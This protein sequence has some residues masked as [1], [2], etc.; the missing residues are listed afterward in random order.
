MKQIILFSLL[1][2]IINIFSQEQQEQYSKIK[3][4]LFEKDI[5]D[6]AKLGL[7]V[8]HGI[9]VKDRFLINDYSFS[10]MKLI[11]KAKFNYEVLIEDV[12]SWYQNQHRDCSVVKAA[13]APPPTDCF[14]S[15]TN[16][17][18]FNTPVNYTYGSMGGYLTYPELL[19]VLDSMFVKFPNL[20]T[21]KTPIGTLAD[22]TWMGNRIQC[23]KI[24]DNPNINEP[25]PE[26]LFTSLH[27][28]REPNSLAQNIFYMWYLLEN[29]STDAEIKYLVDNTEIYFIPCVNPDGYIMNA[30]NYP[31]GGGM[32]RKNG[33]DNDNNGIYNN[34][35][36]VDLNRNYGHQ[37]AYDN[38]GSSPNMNSQTYR[39]P[40]AFSEPE[41]R[42]VRDFCNDHEFQITMNYHTY[43][44]LLI[45]PWGYTDVATSEHETF[46]MLGLEMTQYN[47]Y[48]FG[49]GS[50]T[51]GYTV[52]GDSDDWMYGETVTKGKIYSMTP[53][54][55][56]TG[57]WPM[58]SE[59][60]DLNK[61]VMHQNLS[62]SRLVL[63]YVESIDLN[64]SPYIYSNSGNLD[65]QFVKKGL[66]IGDVTIDFQSLNPNLSFS[67]TPQI[68]SLLHLETQD[69]SPVYNISSAVNDEE[70]KFVVS[71]NN[72]L[73]TYF[74]TIIKIYKTSS[75]SV[76]FDDNTNDLSNWTNTGDWGLTS[77][78]YYTAPNSITD[79]PSSDYGQGINSNITLNSIDLTY[80]TSAFIS[81]WAKWNIEND[82]D[83]TEIQI[84]TDGG[85]NYIPLCGN[86]SNEGTSYQDLGMPLYDGIQDNWVNEIID[87][88]EYVG[89]VVQFRFTFNSDFGVEED[90]FYFDEFKVESVTIAHTH[91][92]VVTEHTCNEADT[93]TT[94]VTHPN[95][96]SLDSVYTV[97][98]VLADT[99]SNT[100]NYYTLDISQV[101][102]VSDTFVSVYGC[103]SIVNIN[104]MIDPSINVYEIEKLE[105]IV[106]PNPIKDILNIELKNNE[107]KV[108]LSILNTLGQEIDKFVLNN[109]SKNFTY[110]MSKLSKG[111]YYLQFNI[112]G[113]LKI[114]KLMK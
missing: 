84:S 97:N 101:G 11:K 91:N 64:S 74:D 42:A 99:Y 26:V 32:I 40:S 111:I 59:I 104:T 25:E 8:D 52:N 83:Y 27:H 107:S 78:E 6:L 24:S 4:D 14:I 103:D 30:Q 7:E 96:W 49:T 41:T 106:F 61:S 88:T 50:E 18:I 29:Y 70:L 102:I 89:N 75:P 71:I 19:N 51:V 56:T 39:G 93:G 54:V 113:K 86:Y 3:I 80:S 43:G 55:G 37:W 31:G 1:L 45:H 82:Y 90:G 47:N 85:V 67:F 60:D 57:F 66:K 110:D 114:V 72:G 12:I 105:I 98:T 92:I 22:T 65:F 48:T 100:F 35:D 15:N 62:V 21:Q 87:I 79:S 46:R 23:L 9:L 81:F 5:K 94:S 73:Y 68:L 38:I 112:K 95:I 108:E 33:R 20:I 16:Q 44:N 10:E 63:N 34:N 76:V 58:M 28:A 77:T 2:F 13:S 36:G 69:V 109:K 17:P 53:E